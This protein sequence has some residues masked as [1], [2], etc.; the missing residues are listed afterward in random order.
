M[1]AQEPDQQVQASAGQG[2]DRLIS[3]ESETYDRL[4]DLADLAVQE[5]R[6]LAPAGNNAVE[7]Y[8]QIRQGLVPTTPRQE[9]GKNAVEAALVD[10]TPLLTLAID[11][12]IET[13]QL[14]EASRLIRMLAAI[15]SQHPSLAR[16]IDQVRKAATPAD[17]N[18]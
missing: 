14:Q 3:F 2:Q 13:R 8:L 10:L 6:V 7:Y 15:D 1:P 4:W 16:Q 5:G 9:L 11:E 17:T 18:P 12:A